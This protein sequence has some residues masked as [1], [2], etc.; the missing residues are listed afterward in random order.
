MVLL[1]APYAKPSWSYV[2]CDGCVKIPT[3]MLYGV[4]MAL[5]PGAGVAVPLPTAVQ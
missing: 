4:A 1:L 3:N 2:G 5:L